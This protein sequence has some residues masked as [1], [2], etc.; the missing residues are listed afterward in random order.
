M[1]FLS[2]NFKEVIQ[3]VSIN[4]KGSQ[5]EIGNPCNRRFEYRIFLIITRTWIGSGSDQKITK[6]LKFFAMSHQEL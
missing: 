1:Y 5:Y 4:D 3:S 6:F 2:V